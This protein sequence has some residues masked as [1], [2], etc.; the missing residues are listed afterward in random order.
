M[1]TSNVSEKAKLVSQINA[2]DPNLGATES[3]T[4][5]ELR[6]MLKTAKAFPAAADAKVAKAA[7]V[8][9]E[10]PLTGDA[11]VQAIREELDVNGGYGKGTCVVA[12]V[13]TFNSHPTIIREALAVLLENGEAYQDQNEDYFPGMEPVVETPATTAPKRY[14]SKTPADSKYHLRDRSTAQKPVA[15]VRAVC[16][17]NPTLARKEI[18]ALCVA[19]GVNHNTAATQYSLYK[20]AEKAAQAAK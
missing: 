12:L 9:E 5:E 14:E 3:N 19:Q 17:A 20:S 15:I 16:A 2:I 6:A 7:A 8:V 18:L 4:R 10:E 1:T 13:A 11:L